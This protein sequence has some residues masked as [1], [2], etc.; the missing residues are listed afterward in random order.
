M[1]YT[2]RTPAAKRIDLREALRGGELLRF[3]GA[4]NGL[5]ARAI[6]EAG[7]EG[8][9]VS[10][11]VVAADLGLPDIGLITATEMANRAQ[12][13]AR[14][15]DLPVLADADTG[16]GEPA[17]VARTVQAYEDAG[18]SG[19]HIE[20]QVNPKRCGHLDSKEIVDE[21]TAVQ[22]IRAAVDS[23]RDPNLVVIARTDI[24]G[25]EG[26]AATLDRVKTLEAAGADMIFPEALTSLREF[27]AVCRAVNVP[28]MAN[29]TEFGK[30]DL[31]S[32]SQLADAGIA[33][34]VFPVSLFRLAMHAAEEGL[35]VL[36]Q[37]GSLA[38]EVPRMQTRARLYELLDYEAY[39]RIDGSLYNFGLGAP[40]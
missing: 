36:S 30:S 27:S 34:V 21:R 3:P 2:T 20:D 24:R 15:T 23:R 10:G 33:V 8:V 17:N 1:L 13:V 6:D 40:H 25:S 26:L 16:Y 19:L 7:M 5:S 22:R 4:F 14:M 39:N 32:T 18:I 35:R 28:V 31:Y 9:Y 29:M 37:D 11:A 12:Q 38:S